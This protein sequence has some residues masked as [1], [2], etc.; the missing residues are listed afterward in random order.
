M[1]IQTEY[2]L[3]EDLSEQDLMRLRESEAVSIDTEMTGLDPN[4]DLLCLVQI[5]DHDGIVNFVRTPDWEKAVNLKALLADAAIMKIFHFALMD[6]SFLLKKTGVEPANLYCTKIASKL[7][8]TYSPDHGLGKIVQELLGTKLDKT[9]QTTFWLARELTPAQLK[10]AA[11]DV[12]WLN[13]LRAELDSILKA[14]GALPTGVTYL[15]LNERCRSMLPTLIQLF[16]NGWSLGE[17]DRGAVFT[18]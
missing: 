12:M 13:E 15:E 16:A 2:T 14:K 17:S 1:P 9:Q 6:C 10:Y 18:H 8:R 4:R 3:Q 7:A 5:C 11:N